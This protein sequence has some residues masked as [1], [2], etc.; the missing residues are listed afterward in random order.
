MLKLK[1]NYKNEVL[2]WRISSTWR[3]Y[4][5]KLEFIKVEFP[6]GKK[7]QLEKFRES[8]IMIIRK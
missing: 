3:V 4:K 5:L 1:F 6:K 2:T 7:N 8:E